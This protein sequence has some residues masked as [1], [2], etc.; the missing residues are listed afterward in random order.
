M[1]PR[2]PAVSDSRQLPV[3]PL[4]DPQT[5]DVS[6]THAVCSHDDE[7]S[8]TPS[9]NAD[10]PTPAP[11]MVML[12]D[13]VALTFVCVTRLACPMS[14]EI[15]AVTLPTSLSTDTPSLL[16]PIISCPA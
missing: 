12:V 10:S 3:T 2:V 8:L 11:H 6:D 15:S 13:P 14:N 16:L 9:V 4:L 5:N 1:L 7:P